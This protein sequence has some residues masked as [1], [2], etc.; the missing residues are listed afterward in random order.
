[1]YHQNTEYRNRIKCS[2][3]N[4]SPEFNQLQNNHIQKVCWKFLYDR[5]SINSTQL[6]VLNEL[7]I[8]VTTATQ[9]TQEAVIQFLNFCTS[10]LYAMIIYRASNM[11][12]S[13]NSD[14]A[15]VVASKSQSRAGGYHYLD[16]KDDTQFNRPMYS[17]KYLFTCWLL[18]FYISQVTCLVVKI[19]LNNL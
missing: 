17:L 18:R 15:Y 5:R 8:K 4:T 6:H 19:I 13:C 12:V 11:I 7:S 2:T 9:Q 1:M 10:N 3:E 16:K 14:A